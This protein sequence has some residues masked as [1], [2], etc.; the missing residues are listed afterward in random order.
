M[1]RWVALNVLV[2]LVCGLDGLYVG[3]SLRLPQM[4]KMTGYQVSSIIYAMVL[5]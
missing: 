3:V 1:T 4:N 2:Y 5:M